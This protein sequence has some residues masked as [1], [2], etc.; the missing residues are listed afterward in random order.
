MSPE[1]LAENPFYVL[2]L[3]VT[4]SRVEVE[5]AGQK[6][7]S[8]L[9]ISAASAKVYRTPFGPRPRDE[10]MVRAAVAALRDPQTRLRHELWV[11]PGSSQAEPPQRFAWSSA[12]L[13][14]GWRVPCTGD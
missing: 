1:R 4:A 6:L 8:L 9:A 3:P 7:L 13:S 14:V 2:E 5:R 11:E 10:A 12:F